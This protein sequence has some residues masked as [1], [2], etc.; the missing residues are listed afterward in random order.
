MTFQL[1]QFYSILICSW[2]LYHFPSGVLA[3]L[4]VDVSAEPDLIMIALQHFTLADFVAEDKLK[5]L[6]STRG[7][8]R[9][10]EGN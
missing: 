3:V 10:M 6:S 9:N 7:F 8:N 2:M 1:Q 4:N 5:D